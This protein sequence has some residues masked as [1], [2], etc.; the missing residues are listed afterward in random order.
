[1]G[2]MALVVFFRGVNVGGHR[3]FRPSVLAKEL[4]VY[5]AVNVGAAGTFVIR[6]PG[7]RAKLLAALRRKVPFDAIVACCD[8]RDLLQLEVDR[9]FET[10]PPGAD[11]VPF[12]SILSEAGRREVAFPVV[13]P[14]G[15]EWLVRIMGSRN[16]LV[17]GVYRRHMKTIGCLGR[18][19]KLFGAPATTRSWTTIL[20]VL[21]ILKSDRPGR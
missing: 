1:M 13:L 20:S 17:Y 19:D 11:V 14:E 12:V 8:G 2:S 5:H 6:K 4:A 16:R 21:R 7:P 10:E 15:E 3:A 9:P 18:I